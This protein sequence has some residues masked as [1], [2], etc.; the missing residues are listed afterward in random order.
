MFGTLTYLVGYIILTLIDAT[1]MMRWGAASFLGGSSLVWLISRHW[2]ISIHAAGVGG[3]TVI[4]L[5]TGGSGLWPVAIAPVA[6]GWARLQLGAH[7]LWQL[8][9]GIA[10]GAAVSGSLLFAYRG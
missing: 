5:V 6:V 3:G 10:L 8:V 7:T 1:P 2:K 4:L 9:A